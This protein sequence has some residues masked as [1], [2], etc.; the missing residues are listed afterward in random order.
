M[1]IPSNH[2]LYARWTANTNTA[3]KVE[4]Y[5]QDVTGSGYTL[6][7]TDNLTGTTDAAATASAKSYT[8]F[9]ENTTHANRVTS[10]TISGDGSLVLK[11]Y[12]DRNTHIVTF[13]DHDSSTLKTEIIRYGGS[14][15]A[16]AS[17]TRTGYTFAGWSG[18]FANITSNLTI[19]ATYAANTYT[20]TFDRQGGTGGDSSSS[21][22]FAGTYGTL[23]A[24][25]RTG[26][27]F[28]GWW[29]SASGGTEVTASTTVTTASNHILFARWTA[30]SYTITF[31]TN[32]GSSV[33][34]ITQ[35]FGTAI[36]APANPT[37]EGYTFTGWSQA[38]PTT[39]P[40]QNLTLT[41][42]WSA[43]SYTITFNTNGGSPVASVTGNF[44]EAISAPMAPTKTG[45]TFAGWDKEIPATMPAEDLTIK[46]LW[47]I[48]S[49]TI[50]FDAAGGSAIAPISQDFGT[51]VVAPEP[52]VKV[53]HTFVG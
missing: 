5:Q 47:D 38:V 42:Q 13:K 32:G 1:I 50:T 28:A 7:E 10:G 27:T 34:D 14:A 36:T 46:A 21:V 12:Y 45:Y 29:T 9:V 48:N 23:S 22:T 11:L 3:Y 41:A 39:M 18:T 20:V 19:N 2:T 17:P 8:G 24:P 33:A 30:N 40:S 51:T 52:P 15:T 44:E 4:H 31:D 35:D 6:F 49:Y 16:P 25:T 53:G 26:Y 43:N 37:R